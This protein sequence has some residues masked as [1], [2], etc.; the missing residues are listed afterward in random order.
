MPRIQFIF[1]LSLG[2]ARTIEQ[3]HGCAD[4]V[5]ALELVGVGTTLPQK[6]YEVHTLMPS[7]ES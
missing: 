3:V 7:L 5:A 1:V 4:K 2:L 6:L